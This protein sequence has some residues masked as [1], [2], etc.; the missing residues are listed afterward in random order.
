M[1]QSHHDTQE[2]A[3]N[4]DIPYDYKPKQMVS[5]QYIKFSLNLPNHF[6]H[7]GPITFLTVP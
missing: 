6:L 2:E 5:L 7:K 1:F 4:K 3:N